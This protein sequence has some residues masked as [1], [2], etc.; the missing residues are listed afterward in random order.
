MDFIRDTISVWWKELR[1]MLS[2]TGVIIFFFLLPLAYPVLYY[3]VY[4]T[5]AARDLPVA[6]VDES[7]TSLSR[8]FARKLDASPEAMVYAKCADMTEA[9]HLMETGEV[10]G[11]VRIPSSFLDDL[12]HGRQ[13]RIGVYADVSSLI[14]YK[15]ILLPCTNISLA[16]NKDIKAEVIASSLTARE[17]EVAK[18]PIDYQHV[19]L[20]NPQGGYAS[21][22][23]PPILLLILQQAMVLGVGMAMGRTRERNDGYSTW[24][25]VRGYDDPMAVIL[26]KTLAILP[27]FLMMALYMHVVV[28]FGFDLPHL[29]DYWTWIGIILPYLLACTC[30]S[31]VCSSMI[32]RREDSLLI[33]VFMSVPLLFLSGVSW[34]SASIPTMWKWVSWLFPSTFGLNAHIKVM[35]MGADLTTVGHEVRCLLF[36]AVAYFV[37]A[38]LLQRWQVWHSER[39]GTESR[40]IGRMKTGQG[41]PQAEGGK[42]KPQEA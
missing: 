24:R 37:V 32:Y 15:N 20:Y 39:Y 28:T 1:E 4:S 21:F 23:M 17:V 13:T 40:A 14:Y 3:Y 9:R 19:Q 5:E 33:F 11:V 16:M 12:R 2:D 18:T 22:L 31:I 41:V 29:G 35:S 25:G 26:G 8:D 27:T 34:P 38:C 7:H 36:Q 6:V 30:F 42:P 10:Y